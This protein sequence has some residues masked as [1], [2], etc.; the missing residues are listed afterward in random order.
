MY[1]FYIS[2]CLSVWEF[3]KEKNSGRAG[4][5]TFFC[6]V[7]VLSTWPPSLNP[8]LLN[9][10]TKHQDLEACKVML[11][12]NCC[13]CEGLIYCYIKKHSTL[14][15]LTPH[16]NNQTT[17][18]MYRCLNLKYFHPLLQFSL[19]ALCVW[20][21]HTERYGHSIGDPPWNYFAVGRL[22]V[23]CRHSDLSTRH[24]GIKTTDPTDRHPPGGHIQVGLPR[25]NKRKRE[26]GRWCCVPTFTLRAFFLRDL[27]MRVWEHVCER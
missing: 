14:Y 2:T 21:Q 3:H 1:I 22:W 25:E 6:G 9:L 19:A 11:L 27:R 4:I 7:W 10:Q 26:A 5:Q 24:V 15:S 18:W 23:Y 13:Y 16:S 12:F 8:S 20:S 17:L